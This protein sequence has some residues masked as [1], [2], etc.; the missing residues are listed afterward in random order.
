MRN[1]I[2]IIFLLSL[3]VGCAQD[4]RTLKSGDIVYTTSTETGCVVGVEEGAGST[5]I[6]VVLEQKL[7]SKAITM[8]VQSDGSFITSFENEDQGTGILTML[9]D[10]DGD[11]LPERRIIS[12]LKTGAIKSEVITYSFSSEKGTGT[13]EGGAEKRKP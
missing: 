9:I 7:R 12:N 8:D 4:K 6:R 10:S 13:K 5:A 11:G 2:Y 1:Y 3:N